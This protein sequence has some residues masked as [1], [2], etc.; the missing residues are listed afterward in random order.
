M[1]R[2]I[3]RSLG[4]LLGEEFATL[5][6]LGRYRRAVAGQAAGTAVATGAAP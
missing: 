3:L 1:V 4:A 2:T 6:D 5:R